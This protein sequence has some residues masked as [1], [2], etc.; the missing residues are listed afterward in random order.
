MKKKID[1]K[2]LD[3]LCRQNIEN[4]DDKVSIAW[5]YMDIRRVPF[6]IA[7][8]ELAQEMREALEWEGYDPEEIKL[9][10]IISA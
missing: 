5:G 3:R 8:P 9:L 10:E 6:E 1:Y 4:Y 7:A 2:E